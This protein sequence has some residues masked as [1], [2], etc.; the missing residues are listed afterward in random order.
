MAIHRVSFYQN[1]SI[2]PD[3]VLA[4][5][6]GLVP[7]FADPRLFQYKDDSQEF[8]ESN[9]IQ[10]SIKF[11]CMRKPEYMNKT[12]KE[13]A[14]MNPEDYLV[15][16]TLLAKDL[17]WI[18]LGNQAATFADKP[19][20]PV[21]DNVII[22]KLRENQEI[23]AEIHCEKGIGKTHAKWQ[24]VCTAYYRLMPDIEFKQPITG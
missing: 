8:G 3:E 22:A 24:P 6:L 7:I 14:A 13:L 1:T 19:I 2:I 17:K 10:F 5:R 21:Y 23:I 9:S 4:H 11:K 18:P 12:D 15:N 20:K 16:H